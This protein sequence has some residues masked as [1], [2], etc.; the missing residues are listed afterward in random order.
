[1]IRVT[2][3]TLLLFLVPF[4]LFSLWLKLGQRSVFDPAH[5]SRAFLGLVIA[6]FLL[7]ASF[8]VATGL[9]AERHLGA[10]VPA[11]TENGQLIPGGFK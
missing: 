6:G 10:Y 2:F 4:V 8:F 11:H 1:M 7:V 5:W 3:E 9:F